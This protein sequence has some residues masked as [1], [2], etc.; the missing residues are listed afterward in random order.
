M[1]WTLDIKTA[2]GTSLVAADVPFHGARI[3]WA[4]DDAGSVEVDLKSGQMSTDWAPGLHRVIVRLDGAAKWQGFV[5]NLTEDSE[6]EGDEASAVYKASGLGLQSILAERIVRFPFE[7]TDTT[8]NIVAALIDEVENVQVNGDMGFQM[9]TV[10][11]SFPTRTRDYCTGVVILDEINALMDIGRGGDWEVDEHGNV[12][13][14]APGRGVNSGESLAKTIGGVHTWSVESDT[15]DMLTNVTILGDDRDPFGPTRKMARRDGMTAAYARH[16][17][18]ID[19]TTTDPDEMYDAGFGVLKAR[20]GAMTTLTVS[21]LEGRGPWP[22][23]AV[24]LQ[25][26]IVADLGPYFGGSSG[27]RCTDITATLD[28]NELVE[29]EYSFGALVNDADILDDDEDGLS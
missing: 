13:L 11:G 9:G 8:D 6:I 28:G 17:E 22:F 26:R 27:M 2:K 18:K 24:W 25:D 23:G 21:W 14:W 10:T 16:E 15:A 1:P 12:N 7:I 3:S 29:C 4:S 19:V 5:T 20:L